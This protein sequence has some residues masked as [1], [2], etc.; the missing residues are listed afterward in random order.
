[1]YAGKPVEEGEYYV[2]GVEE[3]TLRLIDK[4]S[5]FCEVKGRNVSFDNLF[6][7]KKNVIILSTKPV[8]LGVTKDDGKAKPAIVRL[9]QSWDGY[10]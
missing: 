6:K 10:S 4:Y 3:I 5:E 8:L 2:K 1:M 9:H 7:R